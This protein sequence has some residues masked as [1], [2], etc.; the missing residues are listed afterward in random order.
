MTTSTN[1]YGPIFLASTIIAAII[2][3]YD[4][5]SVVVESFTP[6]VVTERTTN[7]AATQ[8]IGSRP[9]AAFSTQNLVTSLY[10][11]DSP[12]ADGSKQK[13]KRPDDSG[14]VDGEGGGG[15][16]GDEEPQVE[17]DPEVVA[18]KAEIAEHEATLAK[19]Q[20]SLQ[21]ALDQCE[22]YSKTGYARKVAEMENMRRVR[23]NM[24]S[25]SQNNAIAGV[26][27]DFLPA[28]DALN[29]LQ[30][31]YSEDSFGG[32]YSELTLGKT[33]ADLG[34]TDYNVE[35]GEPVNN[36]RMKVLENELSTEFAKDTII[37]QT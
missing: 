37:R 36:F 10:M 31:K 23:S 32:A 5:V 21:H 30:A 3:S 4:G 22:E 24:A 8:M 16:D 2:S 14:E 13:K 11:S 9:S 33:F 19:S 18:L 6:S 26:L 29:A 27:R 25:S 1:K 12:G 34:A 20:S 17:E 28:F 7:T 15:G 35:P